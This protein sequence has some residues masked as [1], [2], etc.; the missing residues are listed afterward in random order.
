MPPDQ[1]RSVVFGALRVVLLAFVVI[2]GT[3]I[4]VLNSLTGHP[5]E[6]VNQECGKSA[7]SCK[8]RILFPHSAEGL[9]SGE[10]APRPPNLEDFL[11]GFA[12]FPGL[13]V[14]LAA[15]LGLGLFAGAAFRSTRARARW[16]N[17]LA[18]AACLLV[19]A[20]FVWLGVFSAVWA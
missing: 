20:R 7:G 8:W 6:A 4:E 9:V 2:T 18:A 16:V 14:Y 3:T 1:R 17:G 5:I 15:P 13:L 19:L 10:A 12:S 11:R